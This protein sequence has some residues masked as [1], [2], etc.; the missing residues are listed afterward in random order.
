MCGPTT[1]SIR[2]YVNVA[3]E[4]PCAWILSHSIKGKGGEGVYKRRAHIPQTAVEPR[5][6]KWMK[7]NT[8]CGG[9]KY[10][11]ISFSKK[12]MSD[13]IW[14]TSWPFPQP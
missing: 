9:K 4:V 1:R 11:E 10:G 7:V 12:M 13:E 14:V 2:E 5:S 3:P 6:G 8:A